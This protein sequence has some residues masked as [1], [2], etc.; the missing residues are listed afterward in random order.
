M[1]LRMIWEVNLAHSAAK[2]LN[3][4]PEKDMKYLI[5]ALSEMSEN[6]LSGD[7]AR[8]KSQ[9][10]TLRRRV[11]SWRIFFDIDFENHIVSIAAIERRSSN[12]Y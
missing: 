12:T 8:L 3:K 11:G 2:K 7:L 9:G 10:S 6:P 5:E 4:V 1:I